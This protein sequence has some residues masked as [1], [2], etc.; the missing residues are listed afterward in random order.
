CCREAYLSAEG[1]PFQ[2]E[3][4]LKR[5]DGEYRWVLDRGTPRLKED[6]SFAGYIGCCLDITERK[7]QEETLL[8]NQL[9]IASLNR[10]LQ[11]GMTETHHRVRNSLQFIAAMV[12][13]LAMSSE[14]AIPPQELKQLGMQIHTLA[15]VHSLL[16]DQAK[17]DG[18]A[19]YISAHAVLDS[20]L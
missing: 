2:T 14:E 13:M 1:T 10:R 6:G 12:D 4:R 15:V 8:Q 18:E 7:K 9:Y 16:T 19:R 3:Y 17:H 11:R 5:A 20:L